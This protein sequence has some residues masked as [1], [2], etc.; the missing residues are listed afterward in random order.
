MAL[1]KCDNEKQSELLQNERYIDLVKNNK[2]Y[3]SLINKLTLYLVKKNIN[4]NK[5]DNLKNNFID[6][7]INI[8]THDNIY[9]LKYFLKYDMN[10]I[11]NMKTEDKKYVTLFYNKLKDSLK[12]IENEFIINDINIMDRF[13]LC[14]KIFKTL[15]SNLHMAPSFIMN[16]NSIKDIDFKTFSNYS[17]NEH[18]EKLGIFV[19]NKQDECLKNDKLTECEH[20]KKLFKDTL[21]SE[22]YDKVFDNMYYIIKSDINNILYKLIDIAKKDKDMNKILQ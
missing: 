13:S 5:H 3:N 15:A 21:N 19:K 11:C 8:Y 6:T 17:N 1:T 14:A 18:I 7:I 22:E 16:I 12:C 10:E 9:E 4:V 2:E 20:N